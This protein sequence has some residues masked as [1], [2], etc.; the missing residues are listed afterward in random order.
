MENLSELNLLLSDFEVG[1][2]NIK[3]Y[4]KMA[5]RRSFCLHVSWLCGRTQDPKLSGRGNLIKG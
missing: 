2:S 5:V 3:I 1:S 4:Q